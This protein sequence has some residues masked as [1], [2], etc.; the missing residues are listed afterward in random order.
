MRFGQPVEQP[1]HRVGVA[2]AGADARPP[3]IG[4]LGMREHRLEQA[5]A[6]QPDRRR[7]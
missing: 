4:H 3:D 5:D 1:R 2:E 6:A 7:R